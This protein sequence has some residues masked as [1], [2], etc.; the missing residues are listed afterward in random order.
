MHTF[1]DLFHELLQLQYGV[2]IWLAHI[3]LLCYRC[4]L[5]TVSTCLRTFIFMLDEGRI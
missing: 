3:V 1:L 2:C 4:P 5:M